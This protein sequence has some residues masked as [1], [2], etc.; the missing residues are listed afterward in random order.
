MQ[1]YNT[2]QAK[3]RM[4]ALGS[5][6]IPF[7]FVIDYEGQHA[8]VEAEKDID[9]SVFRYAI[10]GK[11]NMPP[12][13]HCS[14]DLKWEITPPDPQQYHK[15]FER[16]KKALVA[17]EVSLVNLTCRIPIATN[18][19][20][21]DIVNTSEALYRLWIKD[22]LICFSPEMFVQI[23]DGY[24]YSFPMKGTLPASIPDAE[25]VLLNNPKEIAEHADVVELIKQDL[26]LVSEEIEVL[27]YR[28]IDVLNTN[29][30]L[31]LETSSE[32]RGK[33]PYEFQFHLGDILF[34]Q[35]PGG[36]I[37]GFPKNRA[38]AVIAQAEDYTRGYYTG[39]VGRWDG[40]EL[41]SGVLIRFIDQEDGQLYFK[42][43][44]GITANSI[45]EL[46]YNE[47]IAKVYVPIC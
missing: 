36:S 5:K 26:A 40:K 19:S 8:I 39:I 10:R 34:S 32:I 1:I 13:Q 35:L 47:I 21:E 30:G 15:S 11:G 12:A 3:E 41:D 7:V 18:L 20:L 43:G 44:G 45:C 17:G 14:R 27:R 46:E 31:L 22:T 29:K 25:N 28:Y 16:V 2:E 6:G 23:R 9:S 38:R 4:N 37:T 42:A 24:I 33:L